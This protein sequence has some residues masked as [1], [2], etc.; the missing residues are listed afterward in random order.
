MDVHLLRSSGLIFFGYYLSVEVFCQ[1]N[2]NSYESER[3]EARKQAR[4]DRK[5]DHKA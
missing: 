2:G 5:Y 4:T 3:K 1:S